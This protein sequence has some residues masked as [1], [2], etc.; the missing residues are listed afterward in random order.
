[1]ARAIAKGLDRASRVV[2]RV[3]GEVD[4]RVEAAPREALRE[5]RCGAVAAQPLDAIAKG[6][7]RPAP[8]EEGDRVAAREEAIGEE[9]ADE[10]RTADDQNLHEENSI[11]A[12]DWD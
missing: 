1:M 11:P 12:L 4:H 5:I 6:I 2:A 3:G 9:R 7:G 10:L 8:V